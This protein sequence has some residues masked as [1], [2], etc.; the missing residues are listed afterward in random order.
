[1]YFLDERFSEEESEALVFGMAS[2]DVCDQWRLEASPEY[3]HMMMS[4][5]RAL[6][7]VEAK[8]GIV[9][10]QFQFAATDDGERG[11]AHSADQI[12]VGMC[13]DYDPDSGRG[14]S[15][16]RLLALPYVEHP[17]YCPEWAPVEGEL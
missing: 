7:E 8:R 4:H 6:A 12:E 14:L 15:L 10:R 17:D 5:T 1:M 16:L 9:E 3:V 11:C 13:E 2:S